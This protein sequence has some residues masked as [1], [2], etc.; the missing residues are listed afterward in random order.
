MGIWAKNGRKLAIYL[1]TFTFGRIFPRTFRALGVISLQF[2]V[3]WLLLPRVGASRPRILSAPP[4]VALLTPPPPR[5]PRGRQTSA[6][7][8]RLNAGYIRRPKPPRPTSAIVPLYPR[9]GIINK[10]ISAGLAWVLQK[11]GKKLNN[12]PITTAGSKLFCRSAGPNFA[13]KST[14]WLDKA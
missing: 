11:L 10:G 4:S 1:R 8:T 3:C 9:E 12:V 13:R 6:I 5:S 14:F 7:R 2:S